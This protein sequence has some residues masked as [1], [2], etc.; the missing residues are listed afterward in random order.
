MQHF[1]NLRNQRLKR[2]EKITCILAGGRGE[3]HFT[4][5]IK[6][7]FLLTSFDESRSKTVNHRLG[8]SSTLAATTKLK[9]AE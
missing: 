3:G 2:Y 5:I 1:E 7:Q 9:V 4:Y 6:E 8:S